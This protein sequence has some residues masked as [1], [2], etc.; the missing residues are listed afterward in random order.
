MDV[1]LFTNPLSDRHRMTQG[2]PERP[3][4][5]RAILEHLETTGLLAEV[6]ARH[7]E[8]AVTPEALARVH[9]D[10]Y[11]GS[12]EA[13]SPESGLEMLDPD[14][15]LSPGSLGAARLAA[16]AVEEAANLV[17]G[18]SCRRVFCAVRP[19]G[20]H[21]ERNLAMG[22][23]FFNNVALAAA[24]ALDH[25]SVER[26]AILDFDV[27]HGNGTVD[28]FKDTP[29]VMVCSSFQH[30]FYPYR[31]FDLVRDN[32]VHTPLPAGTGSREFRHAIERDWLP[33]IARHR[34]QLLL[35]SAGFDAHAHDPL[36]GL[37]LT[38]DDFRWVTSLIVDLANQHT[39]GRLISTLE[40]G[41]NLKALARSTAAHLEAIL[42]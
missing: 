20:H 39:N 6:E 24:A 8:K 42:G 7:P 30:P 10:D 26:V 35:V 17:L 34:P 1:V 14:T 31:Y 22:F 2:H 9:H 4:R 36:G 19:P 5:A 33:A 27:H 11:I 37:M 41:Y 23:C 25:P 15:W 13:A 38:E 3:A 32:L 16:G 40:G 21:A 28:I 18:G 12:I 29:A